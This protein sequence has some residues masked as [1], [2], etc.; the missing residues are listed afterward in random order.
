MTWVQEQLEKKP[1]VEFSYLKRL[2]DHITFDGW[3]ALKVVWVWGDESTVPYTVDR[4]SDYPDQTITEVDGEQYI[5]PFRVRGHRLENV[6]KAGEAIREVILNTR[7][8]PDNSQR[9]SCPP[10]IVRWE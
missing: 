1:S 4:V 8:I 3:D 2:V 5:G 6:I 7:I 9:F 10:F